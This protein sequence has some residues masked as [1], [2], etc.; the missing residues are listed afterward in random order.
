MKGAERSR[1]GCFSPFFFVW[2]C[3]VLQSTKYSI[4]LDFWA[5]R[6]ERGER[7]RDSKLRAE[8]GMDLLT[9]KATRT[10]S[11]ARLAVLT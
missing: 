4:S 1:V 5:G 7:V 3:C 6:G 10:V 8:S 2:C 9:G 11:I